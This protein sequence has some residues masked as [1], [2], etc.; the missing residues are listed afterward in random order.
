[1]DTDL[2]LLFGVIA[3][4]LEFI[5]SKQLAVASGL[6]ALDKTR[7]L[8]DILGDQKWLDDA[9]RKIV[10]DLIQRKL[11]NHGGDPRETLGAEADTNARDS[12][13][14]I[15]DEAVNLTLSFLP[16]SVAHVR[17]D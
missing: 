7:S 14:D 3:V 13:R 11:K 4:Q 9:D 17:V 1:M 6:W 12:M 15:E 10:E 2:N 8:A 16:P 5:D